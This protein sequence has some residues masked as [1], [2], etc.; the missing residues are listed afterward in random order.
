MELGHRVG[1]GWRQGTH[2]VS[3]A[4]HEGSQ[5]PCH[6]ARDHGASR[7]L[8]KAGLACQAIAVEAD[9]VH[10]A[11][12]EE[13]GS[14]P[15]LQPAQPICTGHR[16][17]GGHKAPVEPRVGAPCLQLPLKLQ[18]CLHYLQGVGEDTGQATG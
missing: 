16:D 5:C 13:A 10:E 9:A 14:Q 7:L 3:R 11:L 1:G 4:P 8:A 2:Q 18:P 17:D 12:V 6:S 15:L